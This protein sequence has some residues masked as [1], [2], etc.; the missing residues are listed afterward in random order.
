GAGRAVRLR[1][2]PVLGAEDRSARDRRRHLP[3]GASDALPSHSLPRQIQPRRAQPGLSVLPDPGRVTGVSPM[4]LPV[5]NLDDRKF[6][7][8]VDEAKRNIP[9]FSPCWTDHNVSDPG[10]TLIELFAWMT[11]QYLFRLNQVPDRNFVTF[12]DLIGVR[13]Q[14]AR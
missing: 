12:L 13:L 10:I 8:L 14:P 2:A 7:D 6:Q 11:E 1:S 4:H 3:G 5:P 9:R